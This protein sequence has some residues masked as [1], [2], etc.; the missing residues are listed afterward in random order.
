MPKK[1]LLSRLRPG[2]QPLPKKSIFVLGFRPQFLALKNQFAFS[3]SNFW[4]RLRKIT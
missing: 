4:L 2:D 3:D 1:R